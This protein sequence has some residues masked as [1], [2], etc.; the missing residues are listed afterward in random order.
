MSADT[1][2][3]QSSGVGRAGVAVFRLSGPAVRAAAVALLGELPV[4]RRA[5]L[6]LVR[7]PVSESVIDQGLALFFPAPASFTGEDVLELQVHGSVAVMRKLLAVLASQPGCRL[8]QAGE[9]SLRGFLNGKMD[10]LEIEALSDLLA[11][12]TELQ[13]ELAVEG[14]AWLRARSEGWRT[15]LIEMRALVEAQIDFGEEGDVLDRLD[16]EAERDVLQFANEID[17]I[18]QRLS[19][20]ERVRQGYRVAVL[21]PPNAGKSSLFNALADRDLAIVSPIAGTTRDSLEASLDIDGVPIVLVDT[22]GI[23]EEV[24]DPIEAEGMRR[25]RIAAERADLALWLSPFDSPAECPEGQFLVVRTKRDL[26][27]GVI[28]SELAISAQTGAGL[29]DL[30]RELSRRALGGG[31]VAGMRGVIAHERQGAALRRAR[32]ALLRAARNEGATL[33]LRAED[34]RV[35]SVALDALIGK[36]EQDE[37][38]SAIFERFC[39]GK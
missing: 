19:V 20:G 13:R 27:E 25:S 9:F 39:I 21:G 2:F 10:L 12:E 26:C 18:L 8:A 24:D 11:A 22:A 32:D 29:S 7:D 31:A 17:S 37:V 14:S 30:C 5:E 4:P 3:A 1:I 35:A 34:L 23:R 28:G 16:S 33:D 6:R 15:R 38:L 36:V